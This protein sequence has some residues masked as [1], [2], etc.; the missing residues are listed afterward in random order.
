MGHFGVVELARRRVEPCDKTMGNSRGP[1]LI[2]RSSSEGLFSVKSRRSVGDP[3]R[4]RGPVSRARAGRMGGAGRRLPPEPRRRRSVVNER[5]VAALT[6]GIA[7]VLASPDGWRAMAE[8]AVMARVGSDLRGTGAERADTGGGPRRDSEWYR[9]GGRSLQRD[10][11]SGDDAGAVR[12]GARAHREEASGAL[13]ERESGGVLH[14]LGE[15]GHSVPDI[16][17]AG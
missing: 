11:L 1:K 7:R 12:P 3:G 13:I 4:C 8:P 5:N 14:W 2:V 17:L 16:P 6:A 10:A 15:L 9:P